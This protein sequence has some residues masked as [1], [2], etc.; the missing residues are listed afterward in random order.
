MPRGANAG[1]HSVEKVRLGLHPL[2]RYPA[3]DVCVG[4][5]KAHQVGRWWVH[6]RCGTA[7]ELSSLALPALQYWVSDGV[8]AERAIRLLTRM[9]YRLREQQAVVLGRFREELGRG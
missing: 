8:D 6:R 4:Q 2:T 7:E 1:Q 3:C 5:G 9:G